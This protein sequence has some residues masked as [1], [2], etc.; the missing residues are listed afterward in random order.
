MR[1]FLAG[2]TG[3]IGRPL[4]PQ[5]IAAGHEVVGTTRSEERA[6]GLRDAGAEAVVVDALDA[7]ALR[8]AVLSARPD[9]VVNQLT[10]LPKDFAPKMRYGSTGALRRDVT[11]TLIEAGREAGATRIVAQSVSFVLAPVGD[12]VKDESGPTIDPDQ[13]SPT[14]AETFRGTLAMERAVVEAGGLVLRYGFFYGP[15]TWYTRDGG[16][17][18]QIRRRMLPVI[19][20][21]EGR[22]SFVHVDDAASATV[23]ALERGEPGV[24]NVVDDEPATMAEWVPGFAEAIGAKPPR[25]VPMWLAKIF[26][27]DNAMQAAS[28]RGST[29]DKARRELGW[30]PRYASWRQGFREGLG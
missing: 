13:L 6:A 19:R 18:K 3:A 29:N 22:F 16:M 25:T 27:R 15:G 5:L 10:D 28:L 26:A 7:G 23:A 20:G 14:F 1:V 12:W 21:A 8:E 2:A 17:A 4:V 11:A 9:A 30:E 24:Y